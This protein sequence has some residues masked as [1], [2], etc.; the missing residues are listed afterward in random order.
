MGM[1]VPA[2][3]LSPSLILSPALFLCDQGIREDWLTVG[4]MYVQTMVMVNALT[5]LAKGSVQ[6]TRPYM[7]N[8]DVPLSEKL[9]ADSRKSFFS[10]HTSNAFAP[11][12]FAATVFGDYFPES[13]WKWA[14]WTVGLSAAAA[15]GY[16]RY[17]AGMHFPTDIITGAVVGSAVGYLVPYFHRTARRN[18]GLSASPETGTG[19]SVTLRF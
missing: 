19:I 17:R 8:P 11:A 2:L 6:R 16:L 7:Y 14:V 15:S 18:V 9:G 1:G 10:G 13:K 3:I 5:E 4:V 12:V